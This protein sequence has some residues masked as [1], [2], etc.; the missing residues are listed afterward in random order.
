[1]EGLS[2]PDEKRPTKLAK[3]VA[4]AA[5]RKEFRRLE[6]ISRLKKP[7]ETVVSNIELVEQEKIPLVVEHQDQQCRTGGVCDSILYVFIINLTGCTTWCLLLVIHYTCTY[8]DSIDGQSKLEDKLI[9]SYKT[10]LDMKLLESYSSE[11]AVKVCIDLSF[12]DLSSFIE[13]PI[14]DEKW[15]SVEK[16]IN[17]ITKQLALSYS[18]LRKHLSEVDN[19]P[20]IRLQITSL[21]NITAVSDSTRVEGRY[22]LSLHDSLTKQG[23]QNWKVG[24]FSRLLGDL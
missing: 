15:F 5:R 19:A 16:E 18:A 3:R 2:V 10:K 24:L 7:I 11:R 6:Q 12:I 4:K 14:V 9:V 17:S 23:F 20:P 13:M 1:M 21:P 8:I 22:A